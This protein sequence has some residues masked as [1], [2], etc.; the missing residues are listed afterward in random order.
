MPAQSNTCTTCNGS[1]QIGDTICSACM[2]SGAI[3]L[4]GMSKWFKE[5]LSAIATEQAA[6]RVDLTTALAAIWNKV[7]NLP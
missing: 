3:P 2:G 7:K 5:T 6:Q 1:G 4:R